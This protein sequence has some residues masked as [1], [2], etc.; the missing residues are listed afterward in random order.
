MD[1][2][3]FSS[4]TPQLIVQLLCNGHLILA[5]VDTGAEINLV[6][7]LVAKRIALPPHD[8]NRPTVVQLAFNNGAPSP[9]ILRHGVTTSLS[10]PHSASDFDNVTLKLGPITGKYD[11]ILGTPFLTQFNLSP[12][13]ATRSLVC[14]LTG[15]RTPDFRLLGTNTTASVAAILPQTPHPQPSPQES[16]EQAVLAEF[17][18]LFP[19]DIPAVSDE[20]EEAGFFKDGAFP[21]KMQSEDSRVCHRII[22]TDPKAVVNERQYPYP[23]KYLN[24]WRVLLDQHLAAG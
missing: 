6:N 23:Q 14:E 10:N 18:D 8:L 20:A 21:E 11:V 17:A 7:D 15:R 9:I 12:S 2:P 24:A 13:L 19:A 1:D 22:L 3:R 5:L 16:S 4:T